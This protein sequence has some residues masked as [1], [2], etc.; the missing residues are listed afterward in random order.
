LPSLIEAPP[1]SEAIAWSIR[2]TT[3]SSPFQL[4]ARQLAL[5][6]MGAGAVVRGLVEDRADVGEREAQLAPDHDLP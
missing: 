1:S 5:G 4:A 2:R 6:A 3:S